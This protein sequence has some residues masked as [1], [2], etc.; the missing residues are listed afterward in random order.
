VV[1]ELCEEEVYGEESVELGKTVDVGREGGS[2]GVVVDI[3]TRRH[4]NAT[5][6][7]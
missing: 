5:K 4:L 3:R 1:V 6:K 2:P 7:E